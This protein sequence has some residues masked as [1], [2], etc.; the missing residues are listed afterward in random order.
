MPFDPEEGPG[1]IRATQQVLQEME[2]SE[3]ERHAI[4]WGNAQRLLT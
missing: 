3:E 4:L 1:F 2:L